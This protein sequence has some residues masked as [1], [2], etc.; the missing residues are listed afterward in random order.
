MSVRKP[1]N[2][3]VLAGT[4]RRDR[5]QAGSVGFPLVDGYPAAPDWLPNAAAVREWDRLVRL[6]VAN[7]ILTDADLT[8]LGHLCAVH[9]K[10]VQLYQ[11][12][13]PANAAMLGVLRRLQ[14]DFGLSPV[15]RGN[16]QLHGKLSQNNNS[17]SGNGKREP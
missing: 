5:K 3:K 4:N 8:S 7:R 2:L 15:G 6:L 16:V 14:N 1:P 17:F 13:V 11:G 10:I 12:G 9:G